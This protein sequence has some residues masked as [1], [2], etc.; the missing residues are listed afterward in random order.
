MPVREAMGLVRVY[1]GAVADSEPTLPEL[2]ASPTVAG[3]HLYEDWACHWTR[4][5][6]T[7]L[8]TPHL[9]FVHR[10]T[11][12]RG[13]RAAMRPDS[14]MVQELD[15][16][17]TGYRIR[18]RL[19]DQREGRLDWV[20]PNGMV[21]YLLDPPRGTVRMHVWCVPLE[22]DRTRLLVAAGYDFGVL[23]PLVALTSSTN[24]RI[25]FEDRAVVESSSPSRVPPPSE[26]ANVPTDKATLRFRTWH[27]RTIPAAQPDAA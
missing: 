24:R 9:P 22:A 8:D 17:P 23:S 1:T 21:L 10:A 18:Y 19:D 4:V 15:E 27:H 20:R 3:G 5:M 25:V 7:M 2:A 6:E 16:L 26:E 13:I 14:R 11:I 12:G